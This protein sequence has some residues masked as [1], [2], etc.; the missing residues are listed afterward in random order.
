MLRHNDTIISDQLD[1]VKHSDIEMLDSVKE[2]MNSFKGH[3]FEILLNKTQ[4]I[5]NSIMDIKK[6]TQKFKSLKPKAGDEK[7]K[8]FQNKG[9][10]LQNNVSNNQL[11]TSIHAT[12]KTGN[13]HLIKAGFA[14]NFKGTCKSTKSLFNRRLVE[15]EIREKH[16][17][18]IK[19]EEN[20]KKNCR[21]SLNVKNKYLQVINNIETHKIRVLLNKYKQHDQ[22]INKHRKENYSKTKIKADN[23]NF[24]TFDDVLN[25]RNELMKTRNVLNDTTFWKTKS[26]KVMN[27]IKTSTF[28]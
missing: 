25:F 26:H 27:T 19:N 3:H 18:L 5:K 24:N 13:K 22:N 1:D 17:R 9:L 8:I 28:I 14:I 10:E 16:D 7:Q 4:S 15:R 23:V 6:F 21:F 11:K 12:K 20:I 2:N